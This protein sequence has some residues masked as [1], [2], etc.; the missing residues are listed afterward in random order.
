MKVTFTDFPP[1]ILSRLFRCH[2]SKSCGSF[3]K[4][5]GDVLE[6]IDRIDGQILDDIVLCLFQPFQWKFLEKFSSW[7]ETYGPAW[8]HFVF[9]F[10]GC[11]DHDSF[12]IH[13]YDEKIEHA[14]YFIIYEGEKV[15]FEKFIQY[16]CSYLVIIWCFF[17][18]AFSFHWLE[19]FGREFDQQ[20]PEI[21]SFRLHEELR[22]LIVK[23]YARYS[24]KMWNFSSSE[25]SQPLLGFSNGDFVSVLVFWTSLLL[26][27]APV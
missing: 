22:K 27:E 15:C 13:T 11:C 18:E 17:D 1:L 9:W 4:F 14:H 26:M 7:L 19:T 8:S 2:F 21:I 20:H 12:V 24:E 3:F 16:F 25:I 5:S 23:T 10:V 6:F